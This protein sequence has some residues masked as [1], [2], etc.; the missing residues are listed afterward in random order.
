MKILITGGTGLL[1]HHLIKSAP[2]AY[3]VSCTFFPAHKKASIPYSCDKHLLDVSDAGEVLAAFRKIRPDYVVH[4]ASLADVDYAE[5]H[6]EEAEKVNMGGTENII[7]AC[8][9]VGAAIIY[10][11]S[12]AVF[13][14]KKPPY[15]EEDPLNPLSYYGCLKAKEED[16]VRKS[17]LRHSIVR[18]ILM[19]GWNLEVE[20]KNSVTW[21]LDAL[22]S[23]RPVN[24][25]DDIF[26]NP[27]FAMDSCRVIW[28]II[29]LNKE[30][31][32]H[33]GGKDELSRYEFAR[34]IADVFG[35]DK[36]L[37]KPVKNEFFSGIAPRP[38]NTTYNIGKI[39]RELGIFPLGSR[40]G[41]E[42]MRRAKNASA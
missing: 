18:A 2:E 29:E 27:L 32:F 28:K 38:V 8:R 40:E 14:G 30:G 17:S 35:L 12:N 26:C 16:M 31:I 15:S 20:R 36:D 4:T 23:G 13:D 11:S 9:D 41:L 39:G 10:I 33:V 24:M 7:T 1:G 5:K 25:V 37:I 19:Y 6:R 42:E 3:K 21:L 22:G 34:V